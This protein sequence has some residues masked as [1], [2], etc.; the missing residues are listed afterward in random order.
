MAVIEKEQRMNTPTQL[1]GIEHTVDELLGSDA[2]ARDGR[3]ARTLVK[4]GPLRLLLVAIKA[5]G[6]MQEHQAAGP[7]TIQTV[8][9]RVTIAGGGV[10]HVLP[11]GEVLTLPA[12]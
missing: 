2:L 12:A 1:I 3:T 8:R 10:D 9:G 6:E 4:S 11:Q 5:G 7:T